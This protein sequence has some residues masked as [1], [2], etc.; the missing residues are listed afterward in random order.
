MMGSHHG[1]V[2]FYDETDVFKW[3]WWYNTILITSHTVDV[4][5]LGLSMELVALRLQ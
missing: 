2:F 1:I 3:I 5:R 4:M